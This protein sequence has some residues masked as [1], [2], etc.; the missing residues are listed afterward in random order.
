MDLGQ[1][2][3]SWFVFTSLYMGRGGNAAFLGGI[4]SWSSLFGK[5]FTG[6]QYTKVILSSGQFS[7]RNFI[8]I[9]AKWRNK[10]GLLDANIYIGG[11]S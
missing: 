11:M 9:A 4:S 6:L 10:T 8:T 3:D 2:E 7:R 5:L 1:L